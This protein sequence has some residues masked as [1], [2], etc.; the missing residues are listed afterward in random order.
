MENV[1]FNSLKD[2]S[3]IKSQEPYRQGNYMKGQLHDHPPGHNHALSFSERTCVPCCVQ[4]LVFCF[5]VCFR[6]TQVN[7]KADRQFS[8]RLLLRWNVLLICSENI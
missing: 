3:V 1:V 4:N 6:Q 5:F 8:F 7:N 2:F